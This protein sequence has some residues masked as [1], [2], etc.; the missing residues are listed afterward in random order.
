MRELVG[1]LL[2]IGAAEGDDEDTTLRKVLLLVAAL[3]IA[4][5]AATRRTSRPA[6]RGRRMPERS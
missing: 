6:S 1:R 2:S 4:P 3:T 5:L